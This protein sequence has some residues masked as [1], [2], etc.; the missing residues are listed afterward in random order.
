M[1][2]IKNKSNG[3][4]I[5]GNV[6]KI[7][8]SLDDFK[9]IREKNYLYVDKTK[10]IEDILTYDYEKVLLFTRPR[11]FGKSLNLSM[12]RYFFD[13]KED[14]RHLFQGLFIE[15][16]KYYETNLNRFPV[17]FLS[18]KGITTNSHADIVET[19]GDLFHDVIDDLYGKYGYEEL[20][21]LQIFNSSG[22]LKNDIGKRITSILY[23]KTQERTVVLIDEYDSLINRT[24]GTA[25]WNYAANITKGIFGELFKSNES[26]EMGVLT[27]VSRIGKELGFSDLNNMDVYGLTMEFYYEYFGFTE[28]EVQEL[29]AQNHLEMQPDF[30]R[31]YNGYQFGN[32]PCMFNTVS[33]LKF[34]DR[35]FKTGNKMLSPYWMN[36]STNTILKDNIVKQDIAFK[37]Q[38]LTMLDGNIIEESIFENIDYEMLHKPEYMIGLLIDTGYLCPIRQLAGNLFEIKVPNEEVMY[39]YRD[40]IDLILGADGATLKSLCSHLIAGKVIQFEE[41][42]SKVLLQVSSFHDFS[43]R[44]NSYHNLMIGALLYLLERYKIRSNREAGLGRYDIAMLPSNTYRNKSRP[45]IIEFKAALESVKEKEYSQDELLILAQKALNQIEE[46]QYYSEFADIYRKD[47]FLLIGI[48]AQGKRCKVFANRL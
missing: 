26:L 29:L 11:R 44:E 43:E 6:N 25:E 13:M 12:L 27:G 39:G 3:F 45:I 17:L 19:M 24:Y 42:L 33:I 36:A 48:G 7:N 46:R 34:L 18:F 28:A 31:M 41:H 1:S 32:S 37:A 22:S 5:T 16:S 47:E 2:D 30:Y 20:K 23:K 35:Y 38:L 40:I 14:S 9:R 21:E 15:Q 10:M 4:N 8:F